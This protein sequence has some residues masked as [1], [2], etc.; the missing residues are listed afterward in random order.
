MA[1]E[2]SHSSDWTATVE[3]A[4]AAEIER[5]RF[6]L[7][8]YLGLVLLLTL[9]T[10]VLVWLRRDESIKQIE[11]RVR[12]VAAATDRL[13]GQHVALARHQV[14]LGDRLARLESEVLALDSELRATP[15]AAPTLAAQ[16]TPA[17]LPAAVRRLP[18]QQARLNDALT[19]VDLRLQ[20]VEVAGRDAARGRGQLDQRL[21][22]L[23]ATVAALEQ[24]RVAAAAPLPAPAAEAAVVP[25]ASSARV[26]LLE[27]R[28]RRLERTTVRSGAADYD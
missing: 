27:Q 24:Q 26:D 22:R 8:A 25:V 7:R 5:R 16:A 17:P 10:L 15:K 28:L 3:S 20:A 11:Q 14:D 23:D 6:W 13:S 21:A 4:V 2:R 9:V 19:A 1:R 18:A 12:P